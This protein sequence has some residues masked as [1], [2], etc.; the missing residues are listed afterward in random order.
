MRYDRYYQEDEEYDHI[1]KNDK[2]SK[3]DRQRKRPKYDDDD[4]EWDDD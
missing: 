1:P 4:Y 2:R 3:R